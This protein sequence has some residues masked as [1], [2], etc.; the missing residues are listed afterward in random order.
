MRAS[1]AL[2]LLLV[3]PVT[4]S[5]MAQAAH[6]LITEDT[7]TQGSRRVQVEFTHERGVEY[8]PAGRKDV[9]LSN[10]VVAVGVRSNVDVILTVPYQ[11]VRDPAGV[12][13][14]IGDLGLDSKWRFHEDGPVFA[15]LKSGV[16]FPSG[17]ENRG[18]GTGRSGWSAFLIST[19]E[20]QPWQVN[21][22]AGISGNNNVVG[23]HERLWHISLAGVWTLARGHKLVADIGVDT[24]PHPQS[25]RHQ[26]FLILGAI[27]AVAKAIDLDIG[28][29]LGLNEFET[30]RFLL[31]GLTLRY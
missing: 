6:P 10:A 3:Y 26:T 18:L 22:H 5:P 27:Y 4:G 31:V 11:R 30:D 17:D 15:A 28:Y 1:T 23:E 9:Q 8:D 7:G 12:Q 21:V 2:A 14:G 20:A 19:Y 24:H 16:T 25:R 13:S 29:K